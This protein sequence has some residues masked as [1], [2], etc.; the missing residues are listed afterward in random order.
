MKVRQ[1]DIMHESQIGFGIDP[2]HGDQPRQGGAM[3]AVKLFLDRPRARRVPCPEAAATKRRHA[4]I[5]L[6]EDAVVGAVQRIVQIEDPVPHMA[7]IEGSRLRDVG[8]W[9]ETWLM[10]E[11]WPLWPCASHVN[12]A[13]TM[14][15]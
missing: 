12:A 8:L 2:M 5:D 11:P 13:S 6:G 4:R 3:I 7:E 14:A 10:G 9:G 15:V 1:I